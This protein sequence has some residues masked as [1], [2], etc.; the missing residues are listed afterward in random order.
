[1]QSVNIYIRQSRLRLAYEKER[2]RSTKM[3][4]L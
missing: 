3:K 2:Y 1:M 4:Y